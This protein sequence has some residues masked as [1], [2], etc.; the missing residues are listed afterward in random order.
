MY[1]LSIPPRPD[2]R[3]TAK[4]FGFDFHT[5]HGAPYWFEEAAYAFTLPQIE[6]DIEDP[7]AELM[8]LCHQ[9]VERASHDDE[10]LSS[11]RIP[12]PW[13][14]PVRESWRRGDKDL[15]ARFDLAYDG[16]GPAKLLELNADTPTALFES[17]FFQWV[18]LGEAGQ[19]GLIPKGCDQFNSLQEALVDAFAALWPDWLTLPGSRTLHFASVAAHAEDRGTIL[20]LRD[21]AHQAGLATVIMDIEA[22]GVDAGGRLTDLEDH[23]IAALFKLYPWEWLIE[24]PFASYLKEPQPPRIIEPCWKMVL[25]TKGL[26]PWL[27]RMFPGHPNLLPAWFADDPAARPATRHVVKPL[28]SREGANV[29]LIDPSLPGGALVMDGPYGGEGWVIQDYHPLP[30]FTDDRGRRHH[31]VIGSWIVAGRPHGVGMREDDGPITVNTSRFVPH[32]ILP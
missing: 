16:H 12:P 30:V 4:R 24:E 9:V 31:A 26:L 7:T 17:A 27:W 14:G 18:W 25:S 10:V 32:L 2:W 29:R 8:A 1:R 6:T 13:W 22:I 3:Q 28:L 5:L 11:L 20:Y 15:Y 23:V 19:G 21:C